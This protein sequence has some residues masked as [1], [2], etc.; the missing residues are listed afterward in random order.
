MERKHGERQG[1]RVW[2]ST[3]AGGGGWVYPLPARA[4]AAQQ[5]RVALA[6]PMAVEPTP[7]PTPSPDARVVYDDPDAGAVEAARAYATR[8]NRPPEPAKAVWGPS[9][10]PPPSP[11]G[12]QAVRFRV[13]DEAMRWPVPAE[14][15]LGRA[16]AAALEAMRV[17]DALRAGV[18]TLEAEAQ[19][20]H[21]ALDPL[22]LD[23]D[24]LHLAGQRMHLEQ[25]KARVVQQREALA[26][27]DKALVAIDATQQRQRYANAWGVLSYYSELKDPEVGHLSLEIIRER[28][29]EARAMIT[30]LGGETPSMVVIEL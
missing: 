11:V 3:L 6:R 15:V 2:D 18:A 17:R 26:T 29:A 7:A 8:N 14:S 13:E 30:E 9:F 16:E 21:R 10:V 19:A 25:I 1:S 23:V 5:F 28:I 22:P 12:A 20:L 24:P 4:P 27:A